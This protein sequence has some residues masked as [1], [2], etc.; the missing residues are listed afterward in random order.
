MN[1]HHLCL[2]ALLSIAC[3]PSEAASRKVLEEQGFT[4]IEL[5]REG[6]HFKFKAKKPQI[7]CTGTIAATQSKHTMTSACDRIV[8]DTPPPELCSAATPAICFDQALARDKVSDKAT[9]IKLY[10][11][12]CDFGNAA[13]CNNLGVAHESGEGAQKDLTKAKALYEKSCKLKHGLGCTNFGDALVRDKSDEPARAAYTQ[14]CELEYADGCYRLGGMLINGE[15]GKKDSTA[16]LSWL[17][18]ACE[19]K[20]P[21]QDACGEIGLV[22]GLGDGVPAD[23]AKGEKLMQA[24]CDAGSLFT[25][26]NLGIL[27]R[28]G[29]LGPKNQAR[30]TALFEKACPAEAT[31]CNELALVY[32]LGLGVTK[33][34]PKSISL[35]EQACTG[36]NV[37]GCTNYAMSLRDGMGLLAKDPKK[38]AY[39]FDKACAMGDDKA[40]TLRK[41]LPA[42]L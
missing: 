27:M 24:A 9:A 39:I 5:V 15:G 20:L 11:M 8:E 32:E 21:S 40:C 36:G 25:C 16:G 33:D 41:G 10:T 31:A 28:D 35:F 30:A 17:T 12:G 22:Y 23:K 7:T 42:K 4:E 3:G 26:T 18:K 6:D 19:A 38:A 1:K 34:L 13:C 14:A 2:T 37:L 29:K